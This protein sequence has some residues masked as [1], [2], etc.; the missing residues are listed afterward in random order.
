MRYALVMPAAGSGAR[1]AAELPKQYAR[2]AGRSL[3][4]WSLQPFIADRRCVVAVV[5]VAA[6]DE[7]WPVLAGSLQ[8]RS[9]GARVVTATGGEQRCHSVRNGLAR[10]A[11]HG[12]DDADW[13]LVHDAARPCVSAEEVDQLLALL[14]AHPL[15]GL[16]ALRVTDTI[17][18]ED[19]AGNVLETVQRAPLWRALTPQMFRIGVLR[20]ALDAAAAGGAMPTDESQAVELWS[21][22]GGSRPQLIQGAAD[23]LKV[24]TRWDL[25]MA[26]SILQRRIA[27]GIA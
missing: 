7:R 19:G 26:E 24:T 15:G 11:E 27:R 23:N 20:A 25:A 16:L 13:V 6:S 8:A 3:I 21:A 22:R 9:V 10:L 1:F 4:E 14:A 17:K 5:A 2:L 12:L 18:R